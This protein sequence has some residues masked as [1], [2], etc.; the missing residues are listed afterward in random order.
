MIQI[1]DYEQIYF[2]L[3]YIQFPIGPRESFYTPE[4]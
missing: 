3:T 2:F 1:E 4:I